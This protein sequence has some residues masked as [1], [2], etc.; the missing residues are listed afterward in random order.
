MS[1]ITYRSLK[2]EDLDR[3]VEIDTTVGGR[4]RKGFFEKRLAAAQETPDNFFTCA[5][6]DGDKLVGFLF[7]RVQEGEFGGTQ[8]VAI[9]DIAGVDPAAQ[10]KGVGKGLQDGLEVRLK[11]AG[12]VALRTQVEWTDGDLVGYF[13]AM[14]FDLSP[15]NIIERNCEP[16]E[17]ELDDDIERPVDAGWEDHSDSSGDDYAALSRDRVMVRSMTTE[18]LA[19]VTRIDSKLTDQDRSAYYQS[20]MAEMI[21][22]TGVR[23]SQIAEMDGAVVGYVMARVDYGEFG[24]AEP[25]AVMDTIGVHP[26]YAND[27]VGHAL[28]SQLLVNLSTLHV[29]T[30]RTQV[31]WKNF[32]LLRFLGECGFEPSQ[33]LVLTKE[34]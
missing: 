7:S 22:E 14:G 33:R 27:G 17:E 16:L 11:K 30:I 18:D 25:A 29:D 34:L 10:G 4:A 19:A 6:I 9:I 24:R 5:A 3:V 2:P 31:S 26:A 28:L 12:I 1:N 23:V 21:G 8:K 13:A 32:D 15:R 20:K